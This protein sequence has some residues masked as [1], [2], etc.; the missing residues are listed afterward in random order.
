MDQQARHHKILHHRHQAVTTQSGFSL[1]V[2][3][4]LALDL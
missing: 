1:E 2:R 4:L 3:L